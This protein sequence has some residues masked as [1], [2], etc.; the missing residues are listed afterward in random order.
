MTRVP[1]S[2][3]CPFPLVELVEKQISSPQLQG[4]LFVDPDETADVV[5]GL[6]PIHGRN[7]L[8]EFTQHPLLVCHDTPSLP[9]AKFLDGGRQERVVDPNSLAGVPDEIIPITAFHILPA[10]QR[11]KLSSKQAGLVLRRHGG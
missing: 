9:W 3:G 11:V 7:L 2:A 10:K 4:G 5:R 8:L 1:S 6:F